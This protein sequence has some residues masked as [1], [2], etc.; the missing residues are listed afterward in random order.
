[1]E[2]F[3]GSILTL[4]LV[5]ILNK[6]LRRSLYEERI[7]PIKYSQAYIYDM[8]SPFLPS[9]KELMEQKE[10][11]STKHYDSMF[12]RVVFAE[13]KAYWIKDSIFYV[14]DVREDGSVDQESAKQVDTMA[15]GRVELEK[16]IFIV[17]QLTEG[18]GNDTRNAGKS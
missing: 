1:M 13:N 3:L 8:V 16:I 2:Y 14:S 7:E 11:Q 10:T 15:M 17:E 5:I 4:A 6:V 18:N 12:L 9:N